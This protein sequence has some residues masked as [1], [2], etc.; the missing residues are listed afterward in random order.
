MDL[1]IVG[2]V[3]WS[4]V[5]LIAQ[6]AVLE[7]L[8]SFDNALALA[9]LVRT[10]LK[11]PEDQRKALTWGIWGAYIFRIFIVFVGVWLMSFEW[12]KA[13]AGL[14]LVWL[15]ASELFFKNHE[16]KSENGKSLS[17]KSMQFSL[18]NVLKLSPLWS[19]IVAVELMDIMFSIDSI[20]VALA[21][22]SE[23]WILIAGAVI[24]IFMMRLAA[25]WFVRLMEHFPLL[26][27]TA[28]VLVGV[29]GINVLLKLKNLPLGFTSLTIDHPIPEHPFLAI[30]VSILII[31]MGYDYC[32]QKS[33]KSI[34]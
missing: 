2:L 32:R 17:P 16:E 12:A 8:L 9:A 13:I 26:E 20:G 1:P 25:Q 7:G 14:Y 27:K 6:L 21:L 5:A 29:A 4:H 23:K 31:S 24:G 19:A 22:S 30:M 33:K 10:R 11:N 28:F 18:G 34:E 15:A 3:T